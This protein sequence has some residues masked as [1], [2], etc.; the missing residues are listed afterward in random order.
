MK[1]TRIKSVD[2]FTPITIKV[3]I[4]TQQEYDALLLAEQ[5]LCRSDIADEYSY[6]ERGVWVETLDAIAEAARSA[7]DDK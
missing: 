3:T 1:A 2:V 4:N 6:R 7:G 5:S